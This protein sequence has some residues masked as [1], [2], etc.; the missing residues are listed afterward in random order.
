MVLHKKI[1]RRTTIKWVMSGVAASAMT[2]CGDRKETKAALDD[3]IIPARPIS[4]HRAS[5][6]QAADISGTPYGTDPDLMQ[7]ANTWSRTMTEKQL[8]VTAALAD[9]FVPEDEHS[10]SA[11][12]VGVPDFL[13]EWISAPYEGQQRDRA[14]ILPG[15]TWIE[16]VSIGRFG[17]GFA[18]ISEAERA[19]I[20]DDVAVYGQEKEELKEGAAFIRRFRS[21]T[22]GAFFSTP[23]GMADIGYRGNQPTAGPY[24]GPSQEALD[25]LEAHLR[26]IGLK[27]PSLG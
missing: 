21:L 27:M 15:L 26:S 18:T 24:P 6:G 17:K 9:M 20:L 25:H 12:A 4:K 22:M 19:S 1:D 5:L 7:P 14:I 23:E 13:D 3:G 11:S 2:A 16:Q 8:A 10:P